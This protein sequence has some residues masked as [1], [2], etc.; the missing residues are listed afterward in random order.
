LHAAPKRLGQI[1]LTGAECPPYFISL[2]CQ[3]VY[4]LEFLTVS[5]VNLMIISL[6]MALCLQGAST[7]LLSAITLVRVSHYCQK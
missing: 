5:E 6:A 2:G 7:D 1:D 3:S 4:V